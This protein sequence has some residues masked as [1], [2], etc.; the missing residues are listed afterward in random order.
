MPIISKNI[1][2]VLQD[3]KYLADIKFNY[4]T[5][6]N[7]INDIN[8]C[9]SKKNKTKIENNSQKHN[10]C[11]AKEMPPKIQKSTRRRSVYAL[12]MYST[13]TSPIRRKVI[14]YFNLICNLYIIK[15]ILLILKKI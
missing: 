15:F 10:I 1:K 14:L 7:I 6:K 5:N 12:R 3:K 2:T 11:K 8:K 4:D 13:D 9:S